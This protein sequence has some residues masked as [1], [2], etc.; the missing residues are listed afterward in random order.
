[1]IFDKGH[2]TM[3]IRLEELEYVDD[4]HS[5]MVMEL[6]T[7]CDDEF[8]PPLSSRHSTTQRELDSAVTGAVGITTVIGGA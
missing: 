7:A 1:M 2:L 5:Q 8:V 3:N 6:L 4:E